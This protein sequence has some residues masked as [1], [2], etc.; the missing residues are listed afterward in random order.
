L[1]FLSR[2]IVTFDVAAGHIYLRPGRRFNRPDSKGV[3]GFDVAKG[4]ECITVTA[5]RKG[6][7][8]DGVGVQAGDS[9][10]EMNGVTCRQMRLLDFAWRMEESK[11]GRLELKLLRNGALIHVSFEV[12]ATLGEDM[13]IGEN[14]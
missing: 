8:A 1:G 2:F 7:V 14:R 10:I 6:S 9:I 13:F 4:A 5:V 3:A 11:G 12:P